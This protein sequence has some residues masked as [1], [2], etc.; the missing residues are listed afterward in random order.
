MRAPGM[1]MMK[2]PVFTWTALCANILIIASFPIL[3]APRAAH[4][5]TATSAPTSS[6][7]TWAAT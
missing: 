1:T 4:R 7:T 3:T 5:W 6:P 2:M